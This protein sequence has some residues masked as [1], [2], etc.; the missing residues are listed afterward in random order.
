MFK[1]TPVQNQDLVNS[2]ASLCNVSLREGAFVYAMNDVETNALMA[3]SQFE[4]LGSEGIIYN[5]SSVP[6]L[7]DFEAIFILGRQTMNFI[8]LCTAHVCRAEKNAAD[9]SML[10]ALGFK[11]DSD[12]FVCDMNGMFDGSHCSGHGK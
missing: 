12:G 6:G 9:E 8:D 3:I 7:D 2:Y 1:I 4:I 11:K 10:V 5:L